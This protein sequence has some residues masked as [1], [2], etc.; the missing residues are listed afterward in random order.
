MAASVETMS[1]STSSSRSQRHPGG[2]DGDDFGDLASEG[3]ELDLAAKLALTRKAR[4]EG[5]SVPATISDAEDD[6][7]DPFGDEFDWSENESG[8]AILKCISCC[9]VCVCVRHRII[10]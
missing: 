6:E 3:G 2:D 5:E 4:Q 9:V 1:L 7:D 8:T 10:G